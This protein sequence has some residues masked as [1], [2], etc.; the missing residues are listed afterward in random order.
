MCEANVA[1]RCSN[2]CSAKSLGVRG[3]LNFFPRSR[4]S[5]ASSTRAA[6]WP[7][8]PRAAW[9][10]PVLRPRKGS[11]PDRYILF[12]PPVLLPFELVIIPDT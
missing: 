6:K 2:C 11:R 1:M 9:D 3:R 12:Q 7:G 5:I 4:S 10:R 8:E